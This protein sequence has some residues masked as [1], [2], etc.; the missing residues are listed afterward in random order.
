MT[1]ANLK[2]PLLVME[3]FNRPDKKRSTNSNDKGKNTI[4]TRKC[5]ICIIV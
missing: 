4:I 3:T 5:H 1:I 2:K